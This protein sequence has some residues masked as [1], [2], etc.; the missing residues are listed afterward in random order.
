[1]PDTDSNMSDLQKLTGH[2]RQ[3]CEERNWDQFHTPKELA[4]GLVTE[5]SELLELFRFKSE[6]QIKAILCQSETR[7]LVADEL[8]DVLFFVLRFAQLN[9]FSLSECLQDK[10]K[11]N[12]QKYPVEKAYGSNRKYNE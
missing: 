7:Q 11:K 2:V 12:A 8:A 10:L 4:I 5:A 9:Q 3:F 1:M 6:D